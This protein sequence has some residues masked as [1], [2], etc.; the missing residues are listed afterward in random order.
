VDL[1]FIIAVRDHHQLDLVLKNL[2]H[3]TC[4]LKAQRSN[5]AG[6]TETK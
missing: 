5:N 3:T 6:H 4:V 1:K 2:R